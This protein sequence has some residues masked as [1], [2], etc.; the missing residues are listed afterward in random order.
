[1]ERYEIIH[2]PDRINACGTRGEEF[3]VMGPVWG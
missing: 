2:S 1:L 3:V